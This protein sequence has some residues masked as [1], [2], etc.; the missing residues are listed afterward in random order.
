[1]KTIFN[2]PKYSAVI[3]SLI[4]FG[5]KIDKHPII[6][7][8][9]QQMEIQT[10][11]SIP[12]GWNTFKYKN[13][14]NETHFIVFEKYPV[15]KGI[16]DSRAEVLPVFDEGMT[17]FNEGKTD[18]GL[19]AF[20]KLPAWFYEVAFT[21]GL[22]FTS[23]NTTSES[24][25]YFEPGNYLMECYVK[26]P[27]GK[28]HS[29]MGMLKE[30]RITEQKRKLK[31]P[32][33]TI[34]LSISSDKG[35]ISN[36]TYKVGEQVIGVTFLDQKAHEHFLGHDVHLVK[37]SN[38]AKLEELD[39]WV[40]WLNPKGLVTPSPKGV[41]FLGGMQEMNKDNTGYFN[42]NLTPGNYALIAEVPEPTKKNMLK[43]FTV[44]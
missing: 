19:A 29:V 2:Y 43:R 5:C 16:D 22:G 6:D 20:G 39:Y 44:K 15:G 34:N 10:V 11:D 23:P 36:D 38:E 18:E 32:K 41:T 8:S 28:F 24:T 9:T 13:L 14:S 26:M 42:V 17:L 21:G 7:I 30:I 37:L 33:P 3:L 35:I 27:N 25:I 31:E 1:M 40:N 4:C 12:S